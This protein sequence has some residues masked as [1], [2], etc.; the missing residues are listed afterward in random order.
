MRPIATAELLTATL[1]VSGCFQEVAPRHEAPADAASVSMDQ[2][3]V[4]PKS[5]DAP[6]VEATA[7]V[8]QLAQQAHEDA[9]PEAR[10]EALYLIADAGEAEDAAVVGQALYDPD[11]AVRMAA[12]EALT[13]IGGEAS[14]DWMLIALGDPEPR[15]RRTAVEALGEIRGDTSRLL[16]EQAMLDADQGVREAAQQMLDEPEFAESGIR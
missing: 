8:P 14:A 6:A 4:A 12:V 9:D 3:A 5:A 10:R 7:T 16:L 2:R 13:G 1:L 15:I 11:E